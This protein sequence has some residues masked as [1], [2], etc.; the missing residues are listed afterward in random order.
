VNTKLFAAAAGRPSSELQRL[1]D[2]V[3]RRISFYRSKTLSLVCVRAALQTELARRGPI[4]GLTSIGP[5][6]RP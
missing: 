1:L 3:Q 4:Y 6:V 2:I 5:E